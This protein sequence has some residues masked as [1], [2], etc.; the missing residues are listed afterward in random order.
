ML[1][2]CCLIPWY[3]SVTCPHACYG[4]QY[5]ALHNMCNA[6]CSG[7]G[8]LAAERRQEGTG[9][10]SPAGWTAGSGEICSGSVAVCQIEIT[11][12][13]AVLFYLGV[14]N[15]VLLLFFVLSKNAWF[16][17]SSLHHSV[18]LCCTVLF[19]SC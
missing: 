6:W 17:F 9:D 18:M 13:A 14:V 19:G 12:R 3:I 11:L 2:V 15:G 4:V 10:G 8:G 5:T 1:L 16:T 7:D